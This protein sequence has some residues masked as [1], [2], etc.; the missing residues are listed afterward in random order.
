MYFSRWF[1]F[2]TN[3]CTN[4]LGDEA[5]G[6]EGTAR[7][8]DVAECVLPGLSGEA[9]GGEAAGGEALEGAAKRQRLD[10]GGSLVITHNA[11][12][13][14]SSEECLMTMLGT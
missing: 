14:K 3:K 5:P 2:C 11:D 12:F 10:A 6:W 8:G 9:A 7:P 1:K 13:L 4:G